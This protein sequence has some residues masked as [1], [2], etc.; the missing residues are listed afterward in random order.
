MR[1]ITLA[2]FKRRQKKTLGVP[3]LPLAVDA[4]YD[5]KWGGNLVAYAY[6]PNPGRFDPVYVKLKEGFQGPSSLEIRNEPDEHV[7][8]YYMDC[9][10]ARQMNEST[11]NHIK[12]MPL[13][14]LRKEF[15]LAYLTSR[16]LREK[17]DANYEYAHDRERREWTDTK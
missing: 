11:Y 1:K 5:N 14:L 15:A 17:I 10:M 3:K 16:S 9:I 7:A 2:D 4:A 8:R 12:N 6:D 13:H